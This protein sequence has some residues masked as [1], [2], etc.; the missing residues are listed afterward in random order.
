VDA[1]ALEDGTVF[2]PVRGHDLRQLDGR[3]V[4]ASTASYPDRLIVAKLWVE[5]DD[6][7]APQI[8]F[9]HQGDVTTPRPHEIHVLAV[10]GYPRPSTAA[11]NRG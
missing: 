6:S 9:G 3:I 10:T 11:R 1:F 8:H 7:G 5:S 2:E 4:I